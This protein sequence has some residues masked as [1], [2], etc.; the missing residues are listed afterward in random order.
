VGFLLTLRFGD[1]RAGEPTIREDRDERRSRPRVIGGVLFSLVG[2]QHDLGW[3]PSAATV[4]C[5][6]AVLA[7]GTCSGVALWPRLRPKELPTSRFYFDHLARQHPDVATYVEALH[8]LVGNKDEIVREL[9]AQVWTNAHIS[10]RKYQW[11][12]RAIAAIIISLGA[13]AIVALFLG[14]GSLGG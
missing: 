1:G 11:A 6:V 5:A 10:R 4:V 14:I 3:L 8:Q 9:A 2:E 12:G 13:L 7:A